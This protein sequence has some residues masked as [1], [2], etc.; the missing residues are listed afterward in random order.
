[1]PA[2]DPTKVPSPVPIADEK[3]NEPMRSLPA[4]AVPEKVKLTVVTP[5]NVPTPTRSDAFW[6][7]IFTFEENPKPPLFP[8]F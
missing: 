7:V 8:G 5:V 2:K 6:P 4:V 3:V 1:L